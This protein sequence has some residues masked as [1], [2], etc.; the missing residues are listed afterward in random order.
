MRG[1]ADRGNG[2]AG[3]YADAMPIEF[4]FDLGA[5]VGVHRGQNLRQLLDDSDFQT[6][7]A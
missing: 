5:K 1:A 6:T 7:Q 4:S 2:R 3:A